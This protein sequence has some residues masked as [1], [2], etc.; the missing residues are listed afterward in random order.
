MYAND[1]RTIRA[2]VNEKKKKYYIVTKIVYM[3]IVWHLALQKV[4]QCLLCTQNFHLIR[5]R[6]HTQWRRRVTKPKYIFILCTQNKTRK[7]GRL[8]KQVQ[9]QQNK[10]LNVNFNRVW[11]TIGAEHREGLICFS[12]YFSSYERRVQKTIDMPSSR[13]WETDNNRPSNWQVLLAAIGQRRF[14]FFYG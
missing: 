12:L 13:E 14:Y 7:S 3:N 11:C 8:A 4:A 6:E 5:F 9:V 2:P 1:E 10:Q